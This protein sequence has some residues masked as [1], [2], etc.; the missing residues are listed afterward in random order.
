MVPNVDKRWSLRP[1]CLEDV[2]T[3]ARLINARYR[4]FT[5]EDQ[6]TEAEMA[7]H[8]QN[9]RLD[10]E[11]D[12][13]ALLDTEGCVVGWGEVEPPG[14]PHVHAEGWVS[15]DPAASGDAEAWDLLL[16]WVEDRAREA[17]TAAA[18]ELRTYLTLHALEQDDERRRAYARLGMMPIRVMHRMR[19][20]FQAPPAAP[21]WPD[22]VVLRTFAPERD[23]APLAVASEEA[24]RDHWGRVRSTLEEE[25]RTWTE[26]IRWQ[27]DAFD[28]TLS[29]LAWDG[30]CVAGFALGR[31][32]LPLDL[33]R[34]VVA[35]LAVRPAWRRRGL[36]FALLQSALGEFHR[37]GCASVELLVD[38]DSLTGALRLYER[39]DM[40]VFR[41]QLIYEKEL[42]PGLDIT[43]RA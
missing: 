21:T 42:R 23:L 15:I 38:S 6:V 25:E 30:D 19:I 20:D 7:G 26:W 33:S 2:P 35:S 41:S 8:W 4:L 18:A 37:R 36:G 12:T 13:C 34:G 1:A 5:G 17:A 24:F 9:P 29:T 32:H 16:T 11:R 22:G 40:R 3:L 10:P 31:P 27:S 43:T 28:P 39:A 14:E